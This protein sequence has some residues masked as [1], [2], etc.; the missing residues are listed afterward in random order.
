[1][2]RQGQFVGLIAE[3]AKSK[4][5]G[6]QPAYSTSASCRRIAFYPASDTIVY[7]FLPVIRSLTTRHATAAQVEIWLPK[8]NRE[9]SEAAIARE[10]PDIETHPFTYRRLLVARPDLVLLCADWAP[11]A[12]S[13]IGWC[14]ILGI[15]T[16]CLQESVIDFNDSD[17]RMRFSDQV[18]LQGEQTLAHLKRERAFI[19][20]NPR[21]EQL[22]MRRREKFE[23]VLAN[24]NFT[25]GLYEDARTAW[26]RDVV[27]ACEAR[28]LDLRLSQ[29]PRDTGDLSGFGSKLLKSNAGR[30]HAQ[31]AEADILVTRFSSLVHEAIAM[32]LRV[33]YY[34]PHG[35]RQ[36]YD[37][38]AD[39]E[40]VFMATSR[41]ELEAAL[42]KAT[43]FPDAAD[44]RLSYM[45]RHFRPH[46][47]LPSTLIAD[48]LM[49]CYVEPASD[50]RFV[51]L[52][53]LL[54][55][56]LAMELLLQRGLR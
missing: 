44:G 18:L 23:H 13:L 33:I 47:Q 55:R 32:G 31:L 6:I 27:S 41:K 17:G 36:V 28:G 7:S 9:G 50:A 56:P 22:E 40:L 24:V 42:D 4:E 2:T 49:S 11:D 15:P 29:H 14:R 53:Y 43:S 34:N 5:M 8:E 10:L 46:E 51:G 37:F 30:V 38:C 16:V 54:F 48:W 12:K 1:M 26:V 39:G 3:A 19:T 35:E 52:K 25:Y 45:R 20:G 21:Y